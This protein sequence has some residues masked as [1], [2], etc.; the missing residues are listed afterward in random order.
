MSN[1]LRHDPE[2]NKEHTVNEA[3]NENAFFSVDGERYPAQDVV[4]RVLPKKI[5]FFY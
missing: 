5:R 1:E 3:L 4:A 2:F